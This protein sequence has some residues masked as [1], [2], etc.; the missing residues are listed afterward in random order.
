ML[1]VSCDTDSP[2]SPEVKFA[3]A[4]HLQDPEIFEMAIPELHSRI[5]DVFARNTVHPACSRI[6][7]MK[8]L[9]SA[10]SHSVTL[11]CDLN[12]FTSKVSVSGIQIKYVEQQDK[13]L[14][15]GWDSPK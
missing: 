5:E 12:G 7:D 9:E 4:L 13:I 11:I 15:T 1:G 8:I 3:V 14:I 6:S 10:E 2:N